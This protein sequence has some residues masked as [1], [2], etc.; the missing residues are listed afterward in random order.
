M[1]VVL[2]NDENNYSLQKLAAKLG[3]ISCSHWIII[4][5]LRNHDI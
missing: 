1:Y 4:F 3:G 2:N 5:W